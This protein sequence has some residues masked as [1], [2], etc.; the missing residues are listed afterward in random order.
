LI[1]SVGVT[2]ILASI[3]VSSF[4]ASGAFGAA[5]FNSQ[6]LETHFASNSFLAESKN[7][8]R[9]EIG[10]FIEPTSL[11]SSVSLD[12]R[13]AR[14]F[15]SSTVFNSHSNI[16]TDQ[17]IFHKSPLGQFTSF[18]KTFTFPSHAIASLLEQTTQICHSKLLISTSIF[19]AS[20]IAFL[21]IVFL[22]RV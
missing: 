6:T 18:I 17:A 5:F 16:D 20:F 4:G 12:G 10:D 8:A 21:I 13:E 11:P 19:K 9:A 14:T 1:S 3:F 22:A 15:V 7:L 2:S